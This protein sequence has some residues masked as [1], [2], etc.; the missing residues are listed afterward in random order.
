MTAFTHPISPLRRRMIDDMR[1]R[2]LS[3]KTQTTQPP[4]SRLTPRMIDRLK[5]VRGPVCAGLGAGECV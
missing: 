3:P 4:L 2:K 1:M 5:S